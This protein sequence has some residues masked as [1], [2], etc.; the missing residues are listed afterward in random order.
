M[1]KYHITFLDGSED[2]V[3]ADEHLIIHRESGKIENWFLEDGEISWTFYE[4]A[5]SVI[6]QNC[7]N[8]CNE[9]NDCE[10]E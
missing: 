7:C 2:I 3:E 10:S 4:P 1:S 9:G 5:K 6:K 8:S